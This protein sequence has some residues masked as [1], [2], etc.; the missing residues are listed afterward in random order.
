MK[1]FMKS[2]KFTSCMAANADIVCRQIST[3]LGDRLGI[4]TEFIADIPWQQREKLLDTGEIQVGWICGLPYVWKADQHYPIELLVAPVMQGERYQ[5]QP[6]YFSDVVVRRDSSF[7]ALADLRGRRWA[8]NEPRSQS[9]Y[10]VTRYT[11]AQR[12]LPSSYFGEAIE[13]GA[14]QVSLQM[15]L[16]GEI[17]ASA[18][19][20]T[21]L[22]LELQQQPGLAAQIRIIDTFGSSPIPPWI[23][24]Q[25]VPADLKQQLRSAFLTMHTDPIGQAILMTG[26]I[27]HF[28]RV[29]DA[30]YDPVRAM[31][32][33]AE[34]V[35]L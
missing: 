27:D 31:I 35:L 3:Y 5:N 17:D 1:S 24:A 7:Q 2:I 8:Y 32:P 4:T 10:Y 22:E 15:I 9:G 20:S 18:I 28:V 21:V 11:L 23:I 14:H 19:D 6:V 26:L 30:D 33:L 16:N 29:T 12:G 34:T 25:Q 13:S